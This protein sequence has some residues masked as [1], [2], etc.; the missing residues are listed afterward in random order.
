MNVLVICAHPDDDVLGSGGTLA[1]HNINGDN[2]YSCILCEHVT[3]RKKK[4][5]HEDFLKQ[6]REAANIIG[7]KDTMFFD[8][9]NIKMNTIPTL[10]LVQ[11]I[12]ESIIR[13]KPAIIYTHHAGDLNDDHKIVFNATMAAIR[14]PER[15]N[16]EEL[17]SNL[18][19]EVLCYEV[20][21]S[22]EWSAPLPGLVFTPNV[23]VDI[24]EAFKLKIRAFQQYAEIIKEYPH[25]RS[26]EN[27]GALAKYRG[28]QS[29]FELAEAFM[30]VRGLR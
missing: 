14:L 27:L 25:P 2:V 15:R 16:T 8:F 19:K 11:S 23:F 21:S 7:I 26:I 12:E 17:P 13:F 28:A 10:D 9:P 4:P 29:G 22:T 24:K 18:I 3:A 30:L 20:P 6:I 1:K 5:E